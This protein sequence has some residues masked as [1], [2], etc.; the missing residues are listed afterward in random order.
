VFGCNF[1]SQA[2]ES[3]QQIQKQLA[4]TL[5]SIGDA[6]ITTDAKGRIMFMNSVAQSVTG[7]TEG[8]ARG[9]LI[10]APDLVLWTSE[11]LGRWAERRVAHASASRA[12]LANKLDGYLVLPEDL[13]D[14]GQPQYFGRNTG[15]VF[16]RKFLQE[17]LSRAVRQ[18]RLAK[19]NIDARIVQQLSEPVQLDA[20]NV[21]VTGGERDSGEGFVLVFGAGFIM[22]LTI[23]MY[24]QMILG[25]VIEK[26][27]RASR[28][29]CF[30]Q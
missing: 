29:F 11:C 16:T 1:F 5:K 9:K 8:E 27:K 20:M 18:Q 10:R 15:D 4:V 28:R 24:G 6:V 19:A 26:R 3:A 7:W 30:R 22:Y 21:G 17:A 12:V 25:A 14:D 23:L 13:L 2:E